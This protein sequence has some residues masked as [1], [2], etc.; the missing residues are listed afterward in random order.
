MGGWKGLE[1]TKPTFC[2][3]RLWPEGFAAD[4]SM[5]YDSSAE[6]RYSAIPRQRLHWG[7][8]C[9][10]N[11]QYNLRL[12]QRWIGQ[13]SFSPVSSHR[14]YSPFEVLMRSSSEGVS[15][16]PVTKTTLSLRKL[17][18]LS[19]QRRLLTLNSTLPDR[20]SSLGEPGGR[21]HKSSKFPFHVI[22]RAVL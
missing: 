10:L 15:S 20:I 8:S 9:Y 11:W 7:V 5:P 14:A 13:T 18:I 17:W 16:R 1:K 19:G 22:S 4:R 3:R 6:W 21:N 12:P 2:R